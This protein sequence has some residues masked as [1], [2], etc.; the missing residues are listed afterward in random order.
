VPLETLGLITI[1]GVQLTTD[2]SVYKPFVWPKRISVLPGIGGSVT[3]QDFGRFKGDLRLRLESGPSQFLTHDC[4]NALDA[5]FATAGGIFTLT[6]WLENEFR[7]VMTDWQPTPANIP[8]LG[9][10]D[11]IVGMLYLYTMD[12]QVDD[13]VKLRGATYGGS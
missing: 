13:I 2:P 12:L 3:I 7:I 1:G 11:E 4:V 8:D 6:D 10:D 9:D 5:L